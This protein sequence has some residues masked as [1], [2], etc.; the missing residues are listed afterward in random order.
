MRGFSPSR[1]RIR[2]HSRRLRDAGPLKSCIRRD[3]C[4]FGSGNAHGARQPYIGRVLRRGQGHRPC[5]PPTRAVGAWT[6][7]CVL[8]SQGYY[9][10]KNGKLTVSIDFDASLAN[11]GVDMGGVS[12]GVLSASGPAVI[13]GDVFYVNG[14]E[15]YLVG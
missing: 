12:L 14:L 13:E 11:V 6:V 4:Q 3:S 15:Y 2:Q 1:P 10:F 5:F 9:D 8:H 7:T